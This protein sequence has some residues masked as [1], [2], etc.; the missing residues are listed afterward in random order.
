MMLF[1]TLTFLIAP[2]SSS[3]SIEPFSRPY[4]SVRVPLPINRLSRTEIPFLFRSKLCPWKTVLRRMP[5]HAA[6]SRIRLPATSC[7]AP[8]KM[9]IP[10]ARQPSSTVLFRKRLFSATLDSVWSAMLDHVAR[11]S[12]PLPRMLELMTVEWLVPCAKLMPSARLFRMRVLE[13][14]SPSV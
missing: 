6:L 10:A 1:S 12:S 11:P 8:P 5:D 2:C 9:P 7:P 13:T 4:V 14:V 3:K